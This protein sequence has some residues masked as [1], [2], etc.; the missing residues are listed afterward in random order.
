MLGRRFKH[1][2]HSLVDQAA[3]AEECGE[4][5]EPCEN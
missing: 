2:G 1:K 3:D 4:S 5:L